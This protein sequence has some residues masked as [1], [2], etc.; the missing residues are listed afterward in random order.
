[1][2]RRHRHDD[3]EHDEKRSAMASIGIA[4]TVLTLLF[5]A[6]LVL[7]VFQGWFAFNA[8]S[9]EVG[10]HDEWRLI[11]TVNPRE[12]SHDIAETGEDVEEL[13]Q[14]IKAAGESKTMEAVVTEVNAENNRFIVED[15][16]GELRSF[17]LEK[18]TSIELNGNDAKLAELEPGD[19]V[20]IVVRVKNG[21]QQLQRVDA[22]RNPDA[23]KTKTD[24]GN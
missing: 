23:D 11:F 21:N 3:D 9:R 8:E 17:E 22:E 13:G 1:M 5:V 12:V 16:E 14:K 7:G 18:T 4:A 15:E 6:V 24:V 19:K 20:L 10:E 2:S